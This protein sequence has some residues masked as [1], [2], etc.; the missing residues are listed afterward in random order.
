[1][2]FLNFLYF[3]LYVNLNFKSSKYSIN[4]LEDSPYVKLNTSTKYVSCQSSHPDVFINTIPT[5][6]AKRLSINSSSRE[7]L[8]ITLNTLR[9]QW[10][11]LV[12][13]TTGIH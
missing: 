7:A 3:I 4:N 1:M 13:N 6:V 2:L 5:R 12:V 11:V 9:R 10:V 8:M